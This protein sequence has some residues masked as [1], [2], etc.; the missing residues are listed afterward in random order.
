MKFRSSIT[1]IAAFA[2][3]ALPVQLAAQRIT[4]ILSPIQMGF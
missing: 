3:L 2:A 1:T 4:P